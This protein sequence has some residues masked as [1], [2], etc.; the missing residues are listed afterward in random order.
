MLSHDQG[1]IRD[2]TIL[3]PV[4]NEEKSIG[5]VIDELLSIGIQRDNILVV[6]GGSVD[7]TAEIARS[8]GVRVIP[9]EGQGK[10]MAIATGLKHVNTPYVLVMDG[11]YTY[12]AT[13]IPRLLSLAKSRNCDLVIGVRLYGKESQRLI[14]K[15]GNKILAFIFNLLFGVRI[16]DVLSGMY[17]ARLDKLQDVGFEMK[18][19]SVEAEIVSHFASLGNVCEEPIEYRPRIDPLLKKLRVIHGF[20]IARD[21]LRLTWRYNP[22]FLI[23]AI[24]SLLTIPGL[25]LGSWVLYRYLKFGFVHHIRGL[26]AITITGIG[27]LSLILAVQSI[28]I[29]RL[30]Q[31]LHR[32]LEQMASLIREKSK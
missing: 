19:F 30:E 25:A 1:L 18:G 31:R 26:A 4:L 11:D 3:I 10:A 12:P 32:K 13:Y 20:Y 29:K 14:F 24:G 27:L 22:A 5:L 16:R 9:Q 6:D 15:L 2:V 28:Y 7:K 23:F 8:R 17:L 21:M